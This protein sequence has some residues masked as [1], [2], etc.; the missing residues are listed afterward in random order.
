MYD[1]EL[2]KKAIDKIFE[3]L[4]GLTYV[5]MKLTTYYGKPFLKLGDKIRIYT[6]ETDYFDTYLL[7]HN[8]TFAINYWLFVLILSFVLLI[9]L[10]YFQVYS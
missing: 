9:N 7:K 8:F 6:N 1:A 3:R 4:N 2:R 5:D 10:H